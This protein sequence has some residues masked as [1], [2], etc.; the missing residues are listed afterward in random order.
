M[1]E[2]IFKALKLE[3]K[4]DSELIAIAKGKNKIP[5]TFKEAFKHIKRQWHKK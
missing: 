3:L 1:L 5:E 4:T 2:E